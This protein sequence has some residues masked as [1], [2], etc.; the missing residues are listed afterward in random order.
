MSRKKI[1]IPKNDIS[2]YMR[3]SLDGIVTAKKIINIFIPAVITFVLLI[4]IMGFV[5]A[6][7]MYNTENTEIYNDLPLKYMLLLELL[8]SVLISF[9]LYKYGKNTYNHFR[10]EL[11][12]IQFNIRQ[13]ILACL[14][15]IPFSFFAQSLVAIEKRIPLF[16]NLSSSNFNVTDESIFIIIL[17]LLLSAV[18]PPLYEELFRFL[19]IKAFNK[20]TQN[21]IIINIGQSLFFAVLHLSILNFLYSFLGGLILGY[22]FN[23]TR[24]IKTTMI[25]HMVF[26][27]F[28]LIPIYNNIYVYIFMLIISGLLTLFA[29]KK[30]IKMYSNIRE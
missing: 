5:Q 21:F 10:S 7:Y 3:D 15:M 19:T 4:L 30:Y 27:L 6:I 20:V 18:L 12:N 26:N 23:Q 16:N 13:T 24:D 9:V 29:F 14:I 28:A 25:A 8:A 11:F 1:K 2:L 22:I 17:T